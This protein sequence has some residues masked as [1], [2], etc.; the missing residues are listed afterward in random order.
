M[1]GKSL[2]LPFVLWLAA[3]S[4]ALSCA[5]RVRSSAGPLPR[6]E[7]EPTPNPEAGNRLL[8]DV[9]RAARSA[10]AGPLKVLAFSAGTTG[11]RIDGLVHVP[12]GA[13]VLVSARASSGVEDLDLHVYGDDGSPFGVDEAPDDL[14]TL[15]LCP[16][17]EVRLYASARIAQGHGLVALGVQSVP[18]DLASK[19]AK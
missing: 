7:A 13:C 11:D 8:K 4:L 2:T 16:D 1:R 15:L 12:R 3:I 9:A 14:P 19:V 10:G 17:A 6:T 5:P 18:E